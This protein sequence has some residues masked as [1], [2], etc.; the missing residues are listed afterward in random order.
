MVLR[1]A[2]LYLCLYLAYQFFVDF[3][4][5]KVIFIFFF[6]SWPIYL[7][8]HKSKEYTKFQVK[9]VLS[10]ISPQLNGRQIVLNFESRMR[11]AP[12]EGVGDMGVFY[13]DEEFEANLID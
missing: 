2:I 7:F 12:D 8:R 9:K 13:R 11:E 4:I 1:E 6:F 10:H 5:S 3:E